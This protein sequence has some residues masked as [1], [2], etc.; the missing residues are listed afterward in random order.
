MKRTIFPALILMLV[1]IQVDAQQISSRGF[2]PPLFT[3]PKSDQE[4]RFTSSEAPRFQ[5]PDY[6]AKQLN[7][8]IEGVV[9][10]MLYVTAE[11]EV[12]YAEISVSSGIREFD[13]AALQSG[14]RASFPAGFATVDGLPH[15]F[16][17]AVP[18]YFLLASDPELYWHSR[19]E[20]ARVQAEYEKVMKTFEGYLMSRTSASETQLKAVQKSME[21][22][23]ATAKRI[24]HLLAEKKE[25]AIIR[26]RGLLDASRD[27]NSPLA[28]S[29]E[30]NWRSETI[31]PSQAAVQ[32]GGVGAG[33]IRMEE[34]TG[35]PTERLS[36]EL[37]LKKTYI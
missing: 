15:D 14:M 10:T 2:I 5:L 7:S 36:Q 12:V 25:R 1:A 29:P 34:L 35:N 22:T 6:P 17:I 9:E 37:E 4:V 20:L 24:H 32:P 23:I 26:I 19:L 16:R 3:L 27:D 28:E 31:D 18:F 30:D 33:I 11:G 8:G 13:H 21:S